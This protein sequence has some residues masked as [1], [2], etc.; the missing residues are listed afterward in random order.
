MAA[1]PNLS[2]FLD[3]EGT[4]V[5]IPEHVS[6]QPAG[7]TGPKGRKQKSHNFGAS[8]V[9]GHGIRRHFVVSNG[10]EGFPCGRANKV[11]NNPYSGYGP[12]E[13]CRQIDI[14]ARGRIL[15]SR[16]NS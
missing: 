2:E 12:K 4:R 7:N 1:K 5:N 3:T 11:V 8:G 10:V 9:D 16:S 13:S 14:I 6:K 15:D